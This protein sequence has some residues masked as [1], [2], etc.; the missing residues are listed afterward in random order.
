MIPPKLKAKRF[1]ISPYRSIDEDRYVAMAIDDS[2]IGFMGGATGV[3]S[4]E[5]KMFKKI[6]EIYNSKNSKTFWIWGIYKDDNLF[7]H[8]ELKESEHTSENE[9]EIVYMVHPECRRNGVMTE[10]LSLIKRNQNIW[11]KRII[12]TI[13]QDNIASLKLLQKWG[14]VNREILI[15]DENNEQY[16]KLTLK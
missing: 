9:L 3:A 13:N 7:G 5:R 12:A 6:F 15:N 1:I 10:I 2:T 8:L 14:I 16:L 4:E 11:N